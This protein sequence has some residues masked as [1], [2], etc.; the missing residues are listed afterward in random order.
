MGI[1]LWRLVGLECRSFTDRGTQSLNSWRCT[2]FNMHGDPEPKAVTPQ[3]PGLDL[4]GGL[5]GSRGR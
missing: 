3:E 5:G 1:W 2:K 4:L